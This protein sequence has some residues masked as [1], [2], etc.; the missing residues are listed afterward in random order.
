MN[1][2]PL[3][4]VN[5]TAEGM[6]QEVQLVTQAQQ[7]PVLEREI[8][9]ER[10]SVAHVTDIFDSKDVELIVLTA[11]LPIHFAIRR[12]VFR[13]VLLRSVRAVLS[14][15]LFGSHLLAGCRPFSLLLAPL[16][17]LLLP[18][19]PLLSK[20]LRWHNVLLAD[21][22]LTAQDPLPQILCA[23][24]LLKPFVPDVVKSFLFRWHSELR[25]SCA[26]RPC[27]HVRHR[28][29]PEPDLLLLV[30]ELN[31]WWLLLLYL[32]ILLLL[33][34]LRIAHA[35]PQLLR[36]LAVDLPLLRRLCI[37]RAV[38]LHLLLELRAD[39]LACGGILALQAE[40]LQALLVAPE[41]LPR[42]AELRPHGVDPVHQRLRPLDLLPY[43]V[44]HLVR[45][46]CDA[47]DGVCH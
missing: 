35:D 25:E 34:L 22:Q 31:L 37:V 16:L 38:F 41:V 24:G 10:L 26:Q 27:C 1:P 17:K 9:K 18:S 28:R 14:V 23:L 8:G 19:G 46:L 36:N 4:V 2:Q 43:A 44:N 29:P 33:L 45:L 7:R 5:I 21:G 39:A 12:L 6:R 42:P 15:P 32:V 3:W 40:E 30:G 11:F 20:P 13:P 47:P